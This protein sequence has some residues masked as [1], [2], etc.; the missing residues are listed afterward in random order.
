MR[1]TLNFS[2]PQRRVT[3]TQKWKNHR[4]FLLP[5]ALSFLEPCPRR[6]TRP[7][8][9]PSGGRPDEIRR[10]PRCSGVD[11]CAD[12]RSSNATLGGCLPSLCQTML[13]VD[14]R[15]Q[16]RVGPTRRQPHTRTLKRIFPPERRRRWGGVG[17]G[18]A[19]RRKKSS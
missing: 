18:G 15:L 13:R 5:N 7:R 8:L 3:L 10:N 2:I 16:S 14:F 17:R 1:C 6:S 11:V 9:R 4:V 19:Q 12:F